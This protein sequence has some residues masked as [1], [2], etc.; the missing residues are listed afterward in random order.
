MPIA[1]I[2]PADIAA[3]AAAALLESGA[4]AGEILRITGPQPLL[5]AEQVE[6]LG[7]VLG[8]ELSFEGLSDEQARAEMEGTMPPEY[9]EAT[10]SYFSDGT[11]DD[12]HVTGTVEQ[13]TGRAPRSF[14]Q[15]AEAHAGDFA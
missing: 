6:I 15:W 9:I 8:R 7:D 5:P 11:Y 13:I 3:V 2:D 4:T 12:G 14:R 1:S 10:F